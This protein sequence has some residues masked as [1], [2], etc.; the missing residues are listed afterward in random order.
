M[1]QRSRR[2]LHAGRV[3]MKCSRRSKR[4]GSRI[5]EVKC[6]DT[7]MVESKE[8]F[9]KII[10]LEMKKQEE[11]EKE[12]ETTKEDDTIIQKNTNPKTT[13]RLRDCSVVIIGETCKICA[14][15]FKS[16]SD[17]I[18][19]TEMRHGD[20]F[21][22]CGKYF[23][24]KMDGSK[25]KRNMTVRRR[26]ESNGNNNGNQLRVT[27][28]IGD[29]IISEISMNRKHLKIHPSAEVAEPVPL[30]DS[31]RGLTTLKNDYKSSVLGIDSFVSGKNHYDDYVISVQPLNRT[32]NRAPRS[33]VLP[34]GIQHDG[35]GNYAQDTC[36][37]ENKNSRSVD[38]LLERLPRWS[39]HPDDAV[40]NN[41]NNNNNNKNSNVKDSTGNECNMSDKENESTKTQPVKNVTD[42]TSPLQSA[43]ADLSPCQLHNDD[44]EIQEVLRITR[45]RWTNNH[46][47]I[48]RKLEYPIR[49]GSVLSDNEREFIDSVKKIRWSTY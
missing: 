6:C 3:S 23:E 18:F 33:S 15:P 31:D 11:E 32:H 30:V 44:D 35:N 27:L 46:A 17:V 19:H 22:V 4:G 2:H 34:E 16:I 5:E 48:K 8:S 1:A 43:A 21:T 14:L 9:M 36:G 49:L 26:R 28:K 20:G 29:E 7:S 41:N 37:I 25:E 45:R 10:G 40:C 39:L 13:L 24:A 38:S 12:K 42:V 47:N